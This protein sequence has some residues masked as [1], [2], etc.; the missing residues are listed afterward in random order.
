MTHFRLFA[1]RGTYAKLI[2]LKK[3]N[4][5]PKALFCSNLLL[6]I[7]FGL[8]GFNS[9]VFGP[10]LRLFC[11]FSNNL[12]L[13]FLEL[14]QFCILIH[15]TQ[16]KFFNKYKILNFWKNSSLK[17]KHLCLFRL[18]L[19]CMNEEKWKKSR[20]IKLDYEVFLNSV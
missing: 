12:C 1:P 14:I 3:C 8:I 7:H 2:F 18:S 5:Y 10:I 13:I 15:K 6:L 9:E 11:K 16:R 17:F 20:A 4:F 19:L